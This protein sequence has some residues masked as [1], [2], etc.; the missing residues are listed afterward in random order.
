MFSLWL[1][2]G[3][4]FW[5]KVIVISDVV[6]FVVGFGV[7]CMLVCGELCYNYVVVGLDVLVVFDGCLT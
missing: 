5:F 2:L 3:D 4:M 6:I 1:G 7:F